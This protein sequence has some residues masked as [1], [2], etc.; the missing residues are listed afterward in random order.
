MT[1]ALWKPLQDPNHSR[2]PGRSKAWTLQNEASRHQKRGHLSGTPSAA[3]S[4]ADPAVSSNLVMEGTRMN[5]WS[6][7]P[8]KRLW[9]P[10]LGHKHWRAHVFSCRKHKQNISCERE[11]IP[12]Y[13]P[14]ATYVWAC[15]VSK[16][17]K[18]LPQAGWREA[19]H[20]K[21][22]FI[23]HIWPHQL[24][25]QDDFQICIFRTQFLK[26]DQ[27]NQMHQSAKTL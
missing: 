5:A 16:N 19:K 10:N 13:C 6:K 4:W 9:K 23:W 2:H 20:C 1:K 15:K 8:P 21:T 7:T 24:C 11:S 22:Q 27:V 25:N 26:L 14:Y 18:P 12:A 17:L 3:A